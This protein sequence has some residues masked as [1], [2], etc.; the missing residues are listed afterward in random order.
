VKYSI[1]A[2]CGVA[3]GA[4]YLFDLYRPGFTKFDRSAPT[5]PEF[6]ERIATAVHVSGAQIRLPLDESLIEGYDAVRKKYWD[7]LGENLY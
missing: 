4:V 1:E 7:E 2:V 6:L 5:E 3:L